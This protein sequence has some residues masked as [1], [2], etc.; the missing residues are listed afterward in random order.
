M[1]SL[2]QI[3][4]DKPTDFLWFRETLAGLIIVHMI[5]N[6]GGHCFEFVPIFSSNLLGGV[7]SVAILYEGEGQCP[8]FVP[9]FSIFP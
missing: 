4:G 9:N 3:V 7:I 8:E 1:S 2:I 5:T 6:E